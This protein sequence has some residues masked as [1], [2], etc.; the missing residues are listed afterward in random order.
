[1]NLKRFTTEE[2]NYIAQ[3]FDEV[4]NEIEKRKTNDGFIFKT[5]DVIFQKNSINFAPKIL[6]LTEYAYAVGAA[7]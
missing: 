3:N 6:T 1:M 4:I 2:L 7:T 5:G